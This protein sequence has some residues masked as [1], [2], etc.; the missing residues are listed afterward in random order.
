MINLDLQCI[1]FKNAHQEDHKGQSRFHKV[2]YIINNVRKDSK[3]ERNTVSQNKRIHE[4]KK[5]E[6]KH[7]YTKP[8]VLDHRILIIVMK[9]WAAIKEKC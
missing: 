3:K 5:R 4:D 6:Y 9:V 8:L 2:N 1:K 7:K